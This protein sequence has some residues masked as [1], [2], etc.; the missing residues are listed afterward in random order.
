MSRL[1]VG[2]LL[3]LVLS[4]CLPPKPLADAP[5][6]ARHYYHHRQRVHEHERRRQ[7]LPL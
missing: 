7:Y 6:P 5:R 4:S 3:S 1:L 2:V